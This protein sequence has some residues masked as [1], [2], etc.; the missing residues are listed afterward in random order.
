[1]QRL[2]LKEKEERRLL[3][4]HCWAY[5]NEF[6]SLPTVEDGEVVDVVGTRGRYIGRGFYQTSGGIAVR[7]LSRHEDEFGAAFFEERI[8]V[9]KSL[10]A[11][12]YPGEPVYRWVYA[13]SDG[14][15]GLVADRYGPLVVAQAAS[16]FY[17]K[18]AELMAQA[19]LK[20]GGV[21]GVSFRVGNE[22]KTF[23]EITPPVICAV[24]DLGFALDPGQGQKTGL[25]LDQRENWALLKPF[26]KG[27]SVLDAHCYHGAWGLHAAKYGAA[28][29]LGVDTSQPALDVALGNA[30]RNGFEEICAYECGDVQEVL[31]REDRYDV[32]VLDPPAL[33]KTRA[34]AKRAAGL[35]QSLNHAAMESLRPG[36]V[37]ITSSCS[38]FVDTADF[39]EALKRAANSAQRQARVLAVRGA[40]PDHPVLLSMPETEYLCCVVLELD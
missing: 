23:S 39:I 6:E 35:Y 12:L 8:A 3:R 5:R 22:L 13:D 21:T 40:A 26:A 20:H 28:S 10:R 7:L 31:A 36:G 32:V 25:F 37:L 9:A 24:R 33:A 34:M 29:V 14:L 27:A 15:S 30:Q 19:F 17:A 4:G 2:V 1:M 18:N 16:P 11:R 38:H